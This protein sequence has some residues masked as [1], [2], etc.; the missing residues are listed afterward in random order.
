MFLLPLVL[1]F[2]P[3]FLLLVAVVELC[4]RGPLGVLAA[5]LLVAGVLLGS[6]RSWRAARTW[7]AATDRRPP[8]L[9]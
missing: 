5:V 7:W 2:V 4:S 1:L 9:P 6:R 3:L 8:P